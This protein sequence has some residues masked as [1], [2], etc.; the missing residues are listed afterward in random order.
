MN[1]YNR[2]DKIPKFVQRALDD[3][4]KITHKGLLC[5]APNPA[6]AVK[7]Q[8]RVLFVLAECAFSFYFWTMVSREK[9][10]GMGH[11]CPWPLDTFEYDGCCSHSCLMEGFEPDF[12]NLTLDE[13]NALYAERQLNASRRDAVTRGPER[14]ALARK[15][16]RDR[17]LKNKKFFCDL[18]NI[19]CSDAHELENHKRTKKHQLKASGMTQKEKT[20]KKRK[21][22]H[23]ANRAAGKYRCNICDYTT[24]TQQNLDEHFSSKKHLKKEALQSSS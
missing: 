2:G 11:V 18:C 24:T 20:H 21:A 1:S 13:V 7:F 10:Y 23:V 14:T 4:Y 3:G 5:W 12:E 22:L 17:A 15:G 9:D 16:L 8:T 19:N 6:D